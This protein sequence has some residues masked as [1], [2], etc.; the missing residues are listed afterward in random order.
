MKIPRNSL[1]LVF[2]ILLLCNCKKKENASPVA[3]YRDIYCGNWFFTTISGDSTASKTW[4]P[5]DTIFFNG[6]IIKNTSSD[7]L[8]DI[9]FDSIRTLT[10]Y[11]ISPK[12]DKSGILSYTIYS[13]FF[14]GQFNFKD[15]NQLH[16]VQGQY[17]SGDNS[18][19]RKTIG[20][21]SKNVARK[22]LLAK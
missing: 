7:S 10:M 12:V 14:Q 21:K 6:T 9:Q 8:I 5:F 18:Y 20:K 4:I 1:I 22:P 11:K 19:L 2:L 15:L 3:D 17:M 13:G 16:M